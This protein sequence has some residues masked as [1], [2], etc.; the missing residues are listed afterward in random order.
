MMIAPAMTGFLKRSQKKPV[1]SAT[2][3]DG[4]GAVGINVVCWIQFKTGE[5]VLCHAK[6]SRASF[7]ET[8]YPRDNP[9]SGDKILCMNA[10]WN[11]F[12]NLL[13]LGVEPGNLT[14]VQ[15]SLR[16]IIVFLVT[17][18]TVR[19]GHKR[20]LSRKTPFDAALLVILAAVLS[21]AINGSAAFFATLGAESF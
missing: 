16:G 7:A 9:F 13:G 6:V 15:I 18:A 12:Q 2:S 11:S 19:L 20:S 21:R 5:V 1:S 3:R 17:L 10:F 8:A 4:G 14:F